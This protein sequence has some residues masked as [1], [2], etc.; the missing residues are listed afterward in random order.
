MLGYAMRFIIIPTLLI[1]LFPLVL[2]ASPRL[3]TAGDFKPLTDRKAHPSTVDRVELPQDALKV[4]QARGIKDRTLVLI[5]VSPSIRPMDMRT[6]ETVS[7]GVPPDGWDKLLAKGYDTPGFHPLNQMNYV[8]AAFWAGMINKVYWVPPTKESVGKEPLDDIK[9]F[10][11]GFGV[12]DNELASFVKDKDTMHGVLNGIPVS[13]TDLKNLPKLKEDAV[14]MIDLTFFADL[15]K[16]EVKTPM[17]D[18]F[19]GFVTEVGTRGLHASEV[20]ISYSTA[21]DVVPLEYRFLGDYLYVWL[22]DPGRLKDGPPL[23]WYLHSMGMYYETF[24]QL[25]D[26]LQ[27]YSDGIKSDPNDASLHYAFSTAYFSAKDY[28]NFKLE[29]DRSVELDPAYSTAYLGYAQYFDAKD[30]P[31][32]AEPMLEAAVKANPV[33]PSVLV[34]VYNHQTKNQ[35]FKGALMTAQKVI[36]LGFNGPKPVAMLG[37]AYQRLGENDKAVA[38]YL[39]ALGLTVEEDS[40]RGEIL[41]GLARTYEADRKIKEALST[42]L[43]AYRTSKDEHVK[44]G[45]AMQMQRLREKWSPFLEPSP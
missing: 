28:D 16:N 27:S 1:V 37:D 43:E 33:N 18:L 14:V 21:N 30:M 13:I 35:D 4:L 36:G 32:A 19:A 11:R 9:D 17:L 31:S 42:Y 7:S 24:Y 29:L 22:T 39:K 38:A 25:E 23:S 41:L 44:E 10:L 34:E 26:V 8:N 3:A 2:A 6:G 15:Y 12:G 5:S 40:M 45:I 20:V